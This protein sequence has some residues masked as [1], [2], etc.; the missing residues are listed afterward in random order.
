MAVAKFYH[1]TRDPLEALLPTLIVKA[2]DIGLRVALRGT[3]AG[4]MQ[5]I[6]RM[7]WLREGFLPHGLAGGPQDA[8]QPVLL[9]TT[10]TPVADL[11]NS[12]G[13]LITLDGATVAADEARALDR[14]CVVFDGTDE[15]A[16]GAARQ[17]WR[18][19]TGAGIEAEYW[20]RETGRWDCKA[21][22]PKA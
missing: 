18:D 12:P 21:R 17:Q 4:R 13:C 7:L 10:P 8:D 9:L 1:L 22:H 5:G 14:L 2:L 15:A 19:L 20:S 6:D 11:P 16:V 3:D